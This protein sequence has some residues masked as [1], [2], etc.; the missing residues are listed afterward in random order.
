MVEANTLAYYYIATIMAVKCFI[1]QAQ[2]FQ[3]SKIC[4]PIS[5]LVC[6]TKIPQVTVSLIAISLLGVF[7]LESL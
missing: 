2:G 4:G 3:L 1:V 6:G 5:R 7:E